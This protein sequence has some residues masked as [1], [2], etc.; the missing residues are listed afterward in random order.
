[1][2]ADIGTREDPA[3]L[4]RVDQDGDNGRTARDTFALGL[5]GLSAVAVET[6]VTPNPTLAAIRRSEHPALRTGAG[7]R[8][9]DARQ[10]DFVGQCLDRVDD[11][12]RTRAG[13]GI[14]ARQSRSAESDK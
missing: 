9:G 4:C 12:P 1:V 14:D 11:A 8:A 2:E 5:P 6:R 7:V 13:P 10:H 3:R